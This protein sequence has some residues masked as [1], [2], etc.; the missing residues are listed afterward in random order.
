MLN[1][2]FFEMQTGTGHFCN[3]TGTVGN[4]TETQK[5]VVIH[6]KNIRNSKLK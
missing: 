3:V 5:N 4:V 6:S 1:N 2:T